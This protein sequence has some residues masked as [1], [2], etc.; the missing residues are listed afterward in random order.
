MQMT[1][2]SLI[3]LTIAILTTAVIYGTD[4]FHAVVV[5]KATAL[6]KD[7]SIIDLIGHTHLIADQR[8]PAFGI[9]SIISTVV[10]AMLNFENVYRM[11][12][13]GLSPIKS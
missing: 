2:I 1:M 8:M 13:L 9:T 4:M 3:P 11:T 10:C 12:L 5:R 6:S 7:T